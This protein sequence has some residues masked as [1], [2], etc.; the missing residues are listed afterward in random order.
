MSEAIMTS[1]TLEIANQGRGAGIRRFA[2]LALIEVRFSYAWLFM[3]MVV[4]ATIWFFDTFMFVSGRDWSAISSNIAQTFLLVGPAGA[5]WSAFVASREDRSGL[6]DLTSSLPTRSLPRHLIVI[7]TPVVGS[8]MAYAIGAVVITLW[9]GREATWGGPDWNLIGFGA[10]VV[11]TCAA[12]GAAAGRL[13]PQRFAPFIVS[14]SLFLYFVMS[15]SIVDFGTSLRG[16][17]LLS[18]PRDRN[19]FLSPLMTYPPEVAAD[20]PPLIAGVVIGLAA[21]SLALAVLVG[22]HGR[23]KTAIPIMVVAMVGFGAA[24]P[25]TTI[26]DEDR[27]V[28]MA[29]VHEGP[30]PVENPPL[31]C[32]GE[33]VT[34]CL[35]QVDTRDL[36]PA[37]ATVDAL[38]GPIAGLPGVPERIEMRADVPSEP[39]ILRGGLAGFNMTPEQL[40]NFLTGEIFFEEGEFGALSPPEQVILAWLIAPVTDIEEL[41]LIAPPETMYREVAPAVIAA[42]H[43]EIQTHADRFAAL[44][45]VEKHAWLETN[46]DALRAGELTLE[47]LP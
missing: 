4:V 21:L 25:M 15:I 19:N 27:A 12:I 39:G 32:A 22:S 24:I 40:A 35:H 34:T 17:A 20:E 10:L 16:W 8:V 47:D 29:A 2:R 33:V 46:W 41:W 44:S 18:Y 37:A 43:D 11:L 28:A 42:W 38:V 7:G 13:L 5:L 30:V 1:P 31:V 6:S 3:P 23:W 26:T 9:Y 36:D 45:T 14:G